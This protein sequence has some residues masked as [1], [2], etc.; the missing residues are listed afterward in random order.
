MFFYPLNSYDLM[1]VHVET[2]HIFQP[3]TLQTLNEN[4][5]QM[6]VEIFRH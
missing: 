5:L 6:N 4:E 3:S 1:N 2:S